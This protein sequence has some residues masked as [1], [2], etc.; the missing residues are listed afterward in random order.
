MFA[1]APGAGSLYWLAPRDTT[2]TY[3]DGARSY[4]LN[5]PQ[6]VPAKLFWSL[7]VYDARTRSEI[8]TEQNKAALRSM[9]ELADTP[10]EQPVELHFGPDRRPTGADG[11]WIQTLPARLVRLL[12]DLRTRRPRLRRQLAAPGLPAPA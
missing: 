2:G 11:R 5:V 12:P 3:L 8:R 7:T 1:R 6:P 10:T 4:T 9:F